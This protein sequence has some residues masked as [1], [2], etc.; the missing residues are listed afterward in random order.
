MDGFPKHIENGEF[1]ISKARAANRVARLHDAH[2]H[3]GLES[4][5][6]AETLSPDGHVGKTMPCL[7]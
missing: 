2:G 5:G 7:P 6:S 4:Q 1:F 3:G